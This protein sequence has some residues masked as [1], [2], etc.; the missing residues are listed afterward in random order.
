MRCFVVSKNSL[1]KPVH[2]VFYISPSNCYSC[3]RLGLVTPV[4][5]RIKDLPARNERRMIQMFE[6]LKAVERNY[7]K[8]TISK[9]LQSYLGLGELGH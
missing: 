6:D 7:K 5:E 4:L 1:K 2:F 9:E 3:I 8:I